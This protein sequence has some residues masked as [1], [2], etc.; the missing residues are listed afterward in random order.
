MNIYWNFRYKRIFLFHAQSQI[1]ELYKKWG[2][3]NR[4]TPDL[5]KMRF[6]LY[7]KKTKTK[8][9]TFEG[10]WYRFYSNFFS[11]YLVN[12]FYFDFWTRGLENRPLF[13]QY[14]RFYKSYIINITIISSHRPCFCVKKKNK[15]N[16]I[17]LLFKL[18]S[19]RI[20]CKWTDWG[21]YK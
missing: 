16:L 4:Y 1:Q 12:H 8:P 15:N 3:T 13:Y 21:T 17:F 2:T 7:L 9:E 14:L 5:R 18:N 11:R 20:C 6:N 10:K 19:Y